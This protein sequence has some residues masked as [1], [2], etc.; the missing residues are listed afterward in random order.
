MTIQS[1]S[2]GNNSVGMSGS[3]DA[4]GYDLTNVIFHG[5][6]LTQ[7]TVRIQSDSGSQTDTIGCNVY[8]GGGG[9]IGSF[10]ADQTHTFSPSS[11][12]QLTFT[13]S[14]TLPSTGGYILF[15]YSNT[16]LRIVVGDTTVSSPCTPTEL[17]MP[18][19]RI[20]GSTTSTVTNSYTM[21]SLT[22][23]G[24][25]PTSDFVG[26]PPPPILVRF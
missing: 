17:T 11:S 13:S 24:V 4:Y 3:Y 26:L 18:T 1:Q 7:V 16:N 9:L 14:Q 23:S 22:Y 25:T 8:N 10:G 20:S 19:A 21:G 15:T 6:T 12:T 5:A 2:C